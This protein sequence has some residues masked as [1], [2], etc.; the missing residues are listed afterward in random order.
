VAPAATA[1]APVEEESDAK[2]LERLMKNVN[3]DALNKTITERCANDP[4]QMRLDKAQREMFEHQSNRL[5]VLK[6]QASDNLVYEALR[7]QLTMAETR[8]EA[9]RRRV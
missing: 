3:I 6:E 8:L 9:A 4:L 7:F 2:A 5:K 1:S